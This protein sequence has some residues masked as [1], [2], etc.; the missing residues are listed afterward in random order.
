MMAAGDNVRVARESISVL[1]DVTFTGK[2]II[3]ISVLVSYYQC[4]VLR[5]V[6]MACSVQGFIK[7]IKNL[8]YKFKITSY[9]LV[10]LVV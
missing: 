2:T 6:E 7:S 5:R 3:R 9:K 1:G 10:E 4:C 8:C